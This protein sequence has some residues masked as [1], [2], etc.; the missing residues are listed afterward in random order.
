[1]PAPMALIA[2]LKPELGEI[3]EDV[4]QV[5]VSAGILAFMYFRMADLFKLSIPLTIGVYHSREFTGGHKRRLPIYEKY[6]RYLFYKLMDKRNLIFFYEKIIKIHEEYAKQ[7]FKGVNTFPIGVVEERT[8]ESGQK[9]HQS[10]SLTIG[11]VGRLAHFKSYNLWMLDVIK[12]LIRRNIDV[13]YLV[14]GYGP[15]EHEMRRRIQELGIQRHVE[16]R[17]LLEYA[18][19]NRIAGGF[20]IFVG[21]GTSVIEAANLGVPALVGIEYITKPLT[22]DYF[23]YLRGH[24]Y[25]E[26][27]LF[28]KYSIVDQI[29]KYLSMN[30]SE[31][32]LLCQ[33]HI[34][35]AQEYSMETCVENFETVPAKRLDP[36][37]VGKYASLRFRVGYTS[38]FAMFLLQCRLQGKTLAQV[39]YE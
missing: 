28:E 21:S 24:S 25:N 36:A 1:M 29:M 11:S 7:S 34:K 35:K 2:P 13:R 12:D 8:I 38:S 14:Y 3:F 31:R 4:A 15:L 19:F 10:G 6:N 27:G 5:H 9:Q 18:D 20:D 37:L 16:L 22:Y 23:A 33:A 39:I 32:D 26:D 17:G 30:E